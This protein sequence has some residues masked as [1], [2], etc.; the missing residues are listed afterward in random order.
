M[1][2]TKRKKSKKYRS[3]AILT[4]LAADRMSAAGRLLI[5]T[6]LRKQAQ[7]IIR[8]GNVYSQRFTAR[9]MYATI[10][11]IGGCNYVVKVLVCVA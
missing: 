3:A 11:W 2:K 7:N 9:Y 4:V 8:Y 1:T 6:W 5:A 10:A